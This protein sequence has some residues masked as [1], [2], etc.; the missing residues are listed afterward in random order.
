MKKPLL[1]IFTL[2][3]FFPLYWMATGSLADSHG[4]LAFPPRIF[5]SHPTLLNYRIILGS[6]DYIRWIG[7]TIYIWILGSGLM[8]LITF[9]AGYVFS[10]FKK[11]RF[12]RIAYLLVL[13]T[14]M[15]PR[16]SMIISQAKMVHFFGLNGTLIAAM[17]PTIFSPGRVF[18]TKNYIDRIPISIIECA[19]VDGVRERRIIRSIIFP[20]CRPLVAFM[21]I[22]HSLTVLGDYLW[23]NIILHDPKKYTYIVGLVH[24][25]MRRGGTEIGIS[26]I[27]IQLAGG[28][29]MFLPMLLIFLLFQRQFTAGIG[30]GAIKE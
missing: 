16:Y 22:M 1:I 26:P 12:V 25:M 29:L 15:I 13:F 18:L 20:I 5:P 11:F 17:L 6:G 14:L 10:V 28:V 23:Q 27:G 7:N 2:F 9:T 8:L 19:R 30:E 24:T 3:L 4:V 21:M